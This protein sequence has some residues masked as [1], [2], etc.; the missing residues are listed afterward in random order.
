MVDQTRINN[1]KIETPNGEIDLATLLTAEVSELSGSITEKSIT[2]IDGGG[3]EH[4]GNGRLQVDSSYF[5]GSI[6]GISNPLSADLDAAD[7]NINNAGSVDANSVNTGKINN[8]NSPVDIEDIL[9]RTG[10]S[11][12]SMSELIQA[13]LNGNTQ[14]AISTQPTANV[15]TSSVTIFDETAVDTGSTGGFAIVSG[16]DNGADEEWNDIVHYANGG[17][18]TVVSSDEA[19]AVHSRTYSEFSGTLELQVSSDTADVTVLGV[20]FRVV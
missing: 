11:D 20:V 5:D 13:D 9:N 18:A 19:G 3:L 4:D 8:A 14:V 7:Y 17:T 1:G 2:Q 10:L 16:F 12:G 6:T 15:G